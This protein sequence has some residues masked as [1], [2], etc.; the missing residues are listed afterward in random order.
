[1]KKNYLKM[2]DDYVQ[3]CSDIKNRFGIDVNPQDEIFP[4]IYT[5]ITENEKST[6]ITE[7]IHQTL[8]EKSFTGAKTSIVKIISSYTIGIVLILFTITASYILIRHVEKIDM[9]INST[10]MVKE[11]V[12]YMVVKKSETP[13]PGKT[14]LK[15][16]ENTVAVPLMKKSNTSIIKGGEFENK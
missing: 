4:L 3:F 14:Y 8:Q 5:L 10:I 1:M 6:R 16:N 15:L 9:L 13:E 12:I 11:N 7:E 2:N